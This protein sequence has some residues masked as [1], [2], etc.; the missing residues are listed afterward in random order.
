MIYDCFL[1]YDELLL[2]EV[3]LKTLADIVDKFILV[4]STHTFSGHDKRLHY[5][6]V[7]DEPPFAA[8]KDQIVHIVHDGVPSDNRWANQTEQRNAIALGLRGAAPDDIIMVSDVDE[9]LDPKMLYQVT[10]QHGPLRLEQKLFYYFFNCKSSAE[11][12]KAFFCRYKDFTGA[13][14]MRND[15]AINMAVSN[16]GW[17]FSYLMKPEQIAKKISRLSQFEYDTDHFRDVERIKKCLENRSDLFE[18]GDH[19]YQIVKL[20]APTCVLNN[21]EKYKDYILQ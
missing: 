3:R 15:P 5:N 20:D 18:R 17:H 12:F 14:K 4:E 6:M 1:F 19:Q 8:Y 11:W 10:G 2:L 13:D 16:A 9:I 7:K 21:P